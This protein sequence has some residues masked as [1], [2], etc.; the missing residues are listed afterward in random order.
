VRLGRKCPQ[1]LDCLPQQG[2]CRHEA[3]EEGR[4]VTRQLACHDE[5]YAEDV[6]AE[7]VDAGRPA[8]R[9]LEL[10]LGQEGRRSTGCDDPERRIDDRLGWPPREPALLVVY[11]RCACPLLPEREVLGEAGAERLGIGR[12]TVD[13]D[14]ADD[15]CDPPEEAESGTLGVA[16]RV[17]LVT[18]IGVLG[19]REDL[20]MRNGCTGGAERPPADLL[21]K[22]IEAIAHVLLGACH[23]RAECPGSRA[24][25][26]N[27]ILF[28]LSGFRTTAETTPRCHGSHSH[29]SFRMLLEIETRADGIGRCPSS[30]AR[31]WWSWRLSCCQSRSLAGRASHDTD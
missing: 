2:P 26:V 15:S 10:K 25:S 31:A 24:M 28:C 27:R 12:M 6:V 14:E 22:V 18:E 3:N 4:G 11:S 9:G 29:V 17:G 21:G 30:D 16:P 19:L 7:E 8:A 20:V 13:L 1:I 5:P 23:E